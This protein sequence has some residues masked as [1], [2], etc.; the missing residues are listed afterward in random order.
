[1]NAVCKKGEASMNTVEREQSAP[2]ILLATFYVR[3][4]LCAVD[5]AGIQEVIRVGSVTLVHHAPPEVVGVI[6]LRGK[7]VTL[8]DIGLILGF[9]KAPPGPDSRVFIIEETGEFFGLL[10]D[11]VGDVFE[12]DAQ[13]EESLPANVPAAQA[14]YFSGVF[15]AGGNV[16]ARLRPEDLLAESRL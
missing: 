4:A 8:L 15:R 6:N 7:I 13:H 16:I 9:A 11:R 14:R 1:M 2:T 3:D 12:L 10:V 5:A